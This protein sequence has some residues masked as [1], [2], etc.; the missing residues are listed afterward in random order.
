[1][2]GDSGTNIALSNTDKITY[3]TDTTVA[4]TSGNLSLARCYLTGVSDFNQALAAA[5]RT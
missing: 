1:M 2:G 4:Q 5:V 3:S